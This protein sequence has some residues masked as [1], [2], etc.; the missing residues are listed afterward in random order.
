MTLSSRVLLIEDDIADQDAIRKRM[1]KD[2]FQVDVLASSSRLEILNFTAKGDYFVVIVDEQLAGLPGE[3]QSGFR[4][5][6]RC[7]WEY[8]SSMR[9]IHF[10]KYVKSYLHGEP[11]AL[12][13]IKFIGKT[14]YPAGD[15]TND[16][17]DQLA[18]SAQ[19]Y[20]VKQIPTFRV[21]DYRALLQN[22]CKDLVSC[23]LNAHTVA[24]AIAA[25]KRSGELLSDIAIFA[26]ALSRLGSRSDALTLGVFGSYGRMEA[27]ESS[28]IEFSVLFD[29]G[30][31]DAAVN[32]WNR[33]FRYCRQVHEISVEGEKKI[34]SLLTKEQAIELAMAQHLNVPPNAF[35]P[36]Y[37]PDVIFD[38]VNQSSYPHLLFRHYQILAEMC[39]AFNPD[40]LDAIKMRIVGYDPSVKKMNTREIFLAKRMEM[41]CYQAFTFVSED[42]QRSDESKFK[43]LLFRRVGVLAFRVMLIHHAK[44]EQYLFTK[45]EVARMFQLLAAPPIIKLQIAREAFRSHPPIDDLFVRLIT[46]CAVAFD[47]YMSRTTT[48]AR[49]KTFREDVHQQFA[50]LF[51]ALERDPCKDFAGSGAWIFD[52]SKDVRNG[53]F[54]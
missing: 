41:I 8:D 28:D 53:A 7:L 23:E 11:H 22:Y 1:V 49:L 10:S 44:N 17:L 33:V 32:A 3:E 9:F 35:V 27:S 21:H 20:F 29:S 2:G 48:A 37:C 15:L 24:A 25:V 54:A 13:A 30:N 46:T 43:A 5:I 50:D 16:C 31:I 45:G 18:V 12:P 51:D 6:L 42:S 19:A 36:V 39:P 47:V 14:Y 4:L 40:L 52:R 26:T 34:G 38:V